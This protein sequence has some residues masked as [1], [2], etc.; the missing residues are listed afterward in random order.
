MQADDDDVVV[1]VDDEEDGEGGDESSQ[2]RRPQEQ[3][4][5]LKGM[6][7]APSEQRQQRFIKKVSS[8]NI[9]ALPASIR[10]SRSRE[11]LS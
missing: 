6:E 5:G 11:S 8:K 10:L 1:I 7:F 2:L 3:Q 9:H 4:G